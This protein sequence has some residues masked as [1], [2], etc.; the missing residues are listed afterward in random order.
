M[1]M[2]NRLMRP[3][4]GFHPE[5]SAWRSAVIAN[6]GSVAASTVRAV[7]DFCIAIDAAGI[8]DR[9]YRLNLFCGT[10]LNSC[11]VPLYRGQSLTG[12]QYGNVIDINVG[13][14][15]SDDYVETGASGG[16]QGNGIGK[17][18]DTG[19][20]GSELSPGNR[21]VSSYDIVSATTNYSPSVLSGNALATMHGIGPWTTNLT[22]AYRTFN[23]V[24]GNVTFAVNTG[25]WLGNDTSTTASVLY[26]NGSP[27]ASTSGQPA[28]GSG[29]T[30]Y[31]ILGR[32]G[33][34]S[35]ARIG[36]YTIGVSITAEQV[37]SLY[38]A[39]QTFQTALGRNV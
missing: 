26:R 16:L 5:A 4:E 31:S 12:T 32:P 23:S 22:V 28:G 17:R 18:L 39:M 6:G 20:D 36:G 3:M 15:T 8:R 37:S 1:P 21:H 29:N 19:L 14:F 11:F 2:N 10:G 33:E 24:G 25:H 27:V 13:P 35:E 30:E 34:Y 7:S 9:F 38:T